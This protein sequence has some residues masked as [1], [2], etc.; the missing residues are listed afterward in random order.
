MLEMSGVVKKV[1]DVKMLEVEMYGAKGV[2]MQWLISIDDGAENFAMRRFIIE[3][4]GYIPEH[5]HW[6]EHEIFILRG[7]GVIGI[8]DKEYKVAERTV[9]YIPPNARHWYK[10]VGDEPLEFLCVIPLKKRE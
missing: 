3:P 6:Y 7:R 9:L 1:E 8:N 4:N 5:N 2:K 10:N